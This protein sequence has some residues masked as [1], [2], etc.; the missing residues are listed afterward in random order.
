M[1]DKTGRND[2][3]PCGSGKKY[4]KCCMNKDRLEAREEKKSE[5]RFA[6]EF[7][8]YME[9]RDENDLFG[10]EEYEVFAPI[11]VDRIPD[12]GPFPH[13]NILFDQNELNNFKMSPPELFYDELSCGMEHQEELD[14]LSDEFKL[15][16]REKGEKPEYSDDPEVFFRSFDELTCIGHYASAIKKAAEF[17]QDAGH[18]ISERLI[19][20]ESELLA[21]MFVKML[22]FSPCDF[23]KD[24]LAVMNAPP[25]SPYVL[26]LLCIEL[27]YYNMREDAD[28]I[29]NCYN[30]FME[31]Y[32]DKSLS[33]GPVIALTRMESLREIH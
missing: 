19:E 33:D 18:F 16:G 32:P 28:I 6:E 4:K 20:T 2:P 30:F 31:Y 15:H 9:N 5:S 7:R 11:S 29:W 10:E 1:N 17:G 24:I 14:M 13:G 8:K 3:C 25:K 27:S 12:Y 26:S 21:E 22:H 23:R